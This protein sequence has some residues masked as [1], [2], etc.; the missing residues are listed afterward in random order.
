MNHPY[1]HITPLWQQC[2][3]N[4][5]KN[6]KRIPLTILP[7]LCVNV[8][9]KQERI[10]PTII[11]ALFLFFYLEALGY[12]ELRMIAGLDDRLA[13]SIEITNGFLLL[14]SITPIGPLPLWVL[15]GRCL[16]TWSVKV[17]FAIEYTCMRDETIDP[18]M[19]QFIATTYVSSLLLKLGWAWASTFIP[20]TWWSMYFRWLDST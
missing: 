4:V 6:N 13:D 3:V 7:A 15:C 12:L 1:D 19:P 5:A 17:T 16:W 14:G 20:P 18:E 8:A 10:P 9:K 2:C 11:Q